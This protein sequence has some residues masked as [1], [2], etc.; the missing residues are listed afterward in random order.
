MEPDALDG[1]SNWYL[2]VMGRVKPGLTLEQVDARFA[3]LAPAIIEATL[4]E[5][6]PADALAGYRK[7]TLG[8]I[9]RRPASPPYAPNTRRH[10][11]T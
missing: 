3:T 11:T 5:N 9:P 2:Q 8:V 7:A 10:C 6:W 1:R 4:P